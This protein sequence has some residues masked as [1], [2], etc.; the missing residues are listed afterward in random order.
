MK[1][2]RLNTFETNS[3]STHTL[4][5]T[6]GKK[7]DE[8]ESG[9][10]MYCSDF[11]ELYDSQELYERFLEGDQDGDYKCDE[12]ADYLKEKK[13]KPLTLAEFVFVMQND[14]IATKCHENDQYRLTASFVK[15]IIDKFGEDSQLDR[16]VFSIIGKW[17][18]DYGMKSYHTLSNDDEMEMFKEERTIDG[19]RVVA[20]GQYGFC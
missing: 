11:E 5:I 2:I 10:G 14:D 8:F 12:Y 6:S 3:S 13:S 9:Q 19:V 7:W 17:L 16:E 18:Y 15:S 4:T 20:F 1:T